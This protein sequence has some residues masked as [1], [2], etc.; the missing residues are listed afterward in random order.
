M[1][2]WEIFNEETPKVAE[3]YVKLSAAINEV[4]AL[5]EKTRA[6]ILVGIFSAT[7]DPVALRHFIRT[8]F[9]V[10]ASKEEI[11]SA[12]LL[13]FNTGVTFA[14]MSVPMIKEVSESL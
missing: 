7:R 12:A 11:Q 6:L 10:G 9:N 1:S 4:G 5:D 14:E 13:A 2:V 3:A 8:A